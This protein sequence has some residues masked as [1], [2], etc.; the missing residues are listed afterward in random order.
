MADPQTLA[1]LTTNAVLAGFK[2]DA[3]ATAVAIALAE[4]S[5]NQYAHNVGPRDDSYGF[6]QI[7]ML[8]AL[9]PDRRE[10][11]GISS[12]AE[13]YDPLINAKAAYEISGGGKNWEPWTAYTS[14]TYR[15]HLPDAEA[16]APKRAGVLDL[17]RGAV[18]DPRGVADAIGSAAGNKAEDLLGDVAG[19][20][21]KGL[22]RIAIIGLATLTGVALVVAGAWRGVRAGG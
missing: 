20:F 17:A 9:G 4:S 8:G 19:P 11:F 13:L 22:G 15:A 16:V 21:L 2:G 12:N 10:R 1:T 18:S 5:G 6:W 14:G 7:N 3:V